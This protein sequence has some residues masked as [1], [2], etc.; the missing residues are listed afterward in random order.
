MKNKRK[1][2]LRVGVFLL[3]LSLYPLFVLIYTWSCV[4]RSDFQGG[5]HGPL[6]AYRHA[7][8]SA[9]VSYTLHERAVDLVTRLMES[10][11][12]DSNVM[13]ARN[14]RIGAQIVGEVKSFAELEPAVRRFVLNGRE[15][16]MDTNQV[17][18]L[19]KDRWRDAR[20]W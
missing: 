2:F 7:L 12:K 3:V 14:N 18:W 1:I 9:V 17:T 11:G 13:D 15:N 4:Y 8:A 20:L 5:R 10:G 19:P 16:S 6:D